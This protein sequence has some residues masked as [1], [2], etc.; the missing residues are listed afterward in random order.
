[1]LN[2]HPS[3]VILQV[4]EILL[5][6]QQ[7]VATISQYSVYDEAKTSTCTSY[8]LLYELIHLKLYSLRHHVLETNIG[9][10]EHC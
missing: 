10:G 2:F 3:L 4:L 7:L 8:K 6:A 5:P 9:G 1:M